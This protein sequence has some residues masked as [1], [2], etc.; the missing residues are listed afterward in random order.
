MIY[1]EF[2]FGFGQGSFPAD[3]VPVDF[4]IRRCI[5]TVGARVY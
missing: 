1:I 4:P 3:R 2:E 5:H